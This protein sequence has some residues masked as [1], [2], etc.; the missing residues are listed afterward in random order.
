MIEHGEIFIVEKNCNQLFPVAGVLL[1]GEADA[2]LN[3][4]HRE[5]MQNIQRLLEK[6][7]EKV[8]YAQ[9]EDEKRTRIPAGGR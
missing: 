2:R 3:S 8:E 6:Y 5:V 4:D 1:F 7:Y 9:R